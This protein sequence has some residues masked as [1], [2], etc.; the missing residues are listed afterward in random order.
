MVVEEQGFLQRHGYTILR[1]LSCSVLAS[2]PPSSPWSRLEQ[3]EEG[4]NRGPK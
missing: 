4:R 1:F 2:W 3:L